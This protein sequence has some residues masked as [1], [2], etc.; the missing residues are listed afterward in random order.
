VLAVVV[1]CSDDSD[2]PIGALDRFRNALRSLM[3]VPKE[4]LDAKIAERQR[5][6]SRRAAAKG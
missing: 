4:E 6:K 1:G 3:A 5:R 2:D